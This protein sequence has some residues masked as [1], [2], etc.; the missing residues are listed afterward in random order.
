MAPLLFSINQ[1]INGTDMETEDQFR[2]YSVNKIQ[3]SSPYIY[4]TGC[5][6][7]NIYM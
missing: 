2:E 6:G 1:S 4:I 5:N 3:N 7:S